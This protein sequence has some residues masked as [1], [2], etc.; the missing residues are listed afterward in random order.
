MESCQKE[1]AWLAEIHTK[2]E[3]EFVVN[4]AK[5]GHHGMLAFL[6]SI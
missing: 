1:G 2:E 5:V 6:N 4:M 3:Q